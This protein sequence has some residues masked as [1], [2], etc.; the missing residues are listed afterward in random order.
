MNI[1]VVSYTTAMHEQLVGIWDRAVR[2]THHFLT[3]ADIEFYRTMVRNEALLA[4]EI[5]IAADEG[6]QPVG[7]IGRDN[8]HVEM[9][10]VDPDCHGQGVGKRLVQHAISQ[11]GSDISVDVNEQNEQAVL[12]YKR[13]GFELVGRS[14]LDGSGRPFPLLHLKLII[15]K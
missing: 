14:E 4:C 5:W 11:I 12:F 6:G 15:D 1:K 13:L 7:F 2:A 3:E 9:L 10:F 8:N